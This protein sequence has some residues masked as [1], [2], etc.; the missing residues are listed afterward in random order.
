ME[1]T[2]DEA[3]HRYTVDGRQVPSVTELVAPL[4]DLAETEDLFFEQALE[5]AAE[6]GTA[7]H[8]YLAHRL[9]GGTPEDFELPDS[10]EGYREAVELFLSEHTIHPQLIETPL[11]CSY[12]A[13]TPDLVA[14]FDGVP[15]I[16]DWKFVATMAKSRVGGQLNGYLYLCDENDIHPEALA[17]VQ[18]LPDG[19][20]RLY[21]TE[22]DE[23]AFLHCLQ[24]YRI[25]QMKHP[26]GR[27]GG[28]QAWQQ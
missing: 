9:T 24:I 16:L 28:G 10:Y 1:L 23:T 14:D 20:Y 3:A 19:T 12:F 8:A 27:I 13:G 22:A 5:L 18:F 21:P 26:R 17:A 2:F 25:K 15:T 4:G 6:R 11:G 7:L